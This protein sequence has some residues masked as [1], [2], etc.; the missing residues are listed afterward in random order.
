MPPHGIAK[1][2]QSME[3]KTIGAFISALRRAHGMT[4]RE[5]GERLFVS[6]KAVSRWERD[7]CTPDLSLI[8]E[9][10][11]IFG[12]TADELLRGERKAPSPTVQAEEAASEADAPKKDA[13]SERQFKHLLDRRMTKYKNLS[14]ISSGIGLFGLIVAAII[15]LGAIRAYIAFGI[16]L[17]FLLGAAICQLCFALTLRMKEDEEDETDDR[18][19]LLFDFNEKIL[20]KA[21]NVLWLHFELLA[22]C[23]PLTMTGNA[24]YGLNFDSWLLYGL[25]FAAVGVILWHSVYE[26]FVR[27]LLIRKELISDTAAYPAQRRLLSR[28]LCLLVA[29]GIVTLLAVAV[30]QSLDTTAFVR[31]YV[32]ET[33][34]EFMEFM[35]IRD[36]HDEYYTWDEDDNI[37]VNVDSVPV[38]PGDTVPGDESIDEDF[39]YDESLREYIYDEDGNVLFSYINRRRS[40]R[41]ELSD[42]PDRF[43][44]KVYTQALLRRGNNIMENVTTAIALAYG[45]FGAVA[46]A[47]Y[48]KK[49]LE[50]EVSK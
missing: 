8:P 24:Y 38:A 28:S 42:T 7:E 50:S 12:V 33:K 15:N 6:D 20:L 5:L 25:A 22:F 40:A 26:L 3:K 19:R 39:T 9:I 18:R 11:D 4:Q 49:R 17:V 27:R 14:L 41:I 34:E 30:V 10:A 32:F 29:V 23:L 37:F 43:P 13:R 2:E 45:V 46:V 47:V 21:K 36:S 16:A 44:I 1:G 31:P 35:A 48:V